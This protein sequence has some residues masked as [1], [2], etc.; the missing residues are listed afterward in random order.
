[1]CSMHYTELPSD[2]PL[3]R[4]VRCFWFLRGTLE[5]IGPVPQ[6]VV[7][8]GRLEIVLHLGDPFAHDDGLDPHDYRPIENGGARNRR[9][10]GR[11][12]RVNRQAPALLCGQLTAPIRLIATGLT[13]IVGIRFRTAAAASLLRIPLAELTDR[14]APLGEVAGDLAGELLGAASRARAPWQRVAALTAVLT[15]A[16][17]RE[18]DPFAASVV[19][20][21]DSDRAP[22]V[23]RIADEYR[24]SARTIERRVLD[25]TGL[26][27]GLL[28][29]VMRFRRAFREIDRAPPGTWSRVAAGT[30]YYDQAHLIRDFQQFAGAP[31]SRFFVTQPDLARS[32]MGSGG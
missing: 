7:A 10:V 9:D 20:S 14:I 25:A 6:V 32:I 28:R 1:M 15:R 24:V 12:V 3:G 30:G 29:R 22:P 8:D 4:V 5:Q 2:P 17:S 16:M 13:D 23:G 18:P 11:E 27:P 19:R 21:L 26:S 31:P